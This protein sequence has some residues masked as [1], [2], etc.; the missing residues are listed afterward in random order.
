MPGTAIKSVQINDQPPDA[1]PGTAWLAIT[2]AY[3]KPQTLP[4]FLVH[5][6]GRWEAD[7]AAAAIRDRFVQLGLRRVVAYDTLPPGADPDPNALFG[8]AL[9]RWGIKR[10]ATGAPSHNLGKHADSWAVLQAKLA[11]LAKKYRVR[12]TLTRYQPLGKA[13]LVW[14]TTRL[15]ARFIAAG[16]FESLE[17]ILHLREARYDGVFVGL[18]NPYKAGLLVWTS[19]RGR[20][21]EGCGWFHPFRGIDRICPSQ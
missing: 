9:P 20:P 11:T 2:V 16:G 3:P 15:P 4:A 12:A 5:T 21:G 8:I 7:V 13:P 17:R 19:H 14:V 1:P 18:L 6:R 10:W